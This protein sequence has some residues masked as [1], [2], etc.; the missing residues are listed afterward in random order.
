MTVFFPGVYGMGNF[1]MKNC[2]LSFFRWWA[3]RWDTSTQAML[4]VARHGTLGNWCP[5]CQWEFQDPKMKVLY[6]IRSHFVG[7]S[8]YIYGR[9]LQFRFLKWPLILGM[10]NPEFPSWGNASKIA[11]LVGPELPA[12]KSNKSM[13]YFMI[14]S[15]LAI[16][17]L[18][19]S[20]DRIGTQWHSQWW[21]PESTYL[22]YFP[23]GLYQAQLASSLQK[24]RVWRVGMRRTESGHRFILGTRQ[25]EFAC[26]FPVAGCWSCFNSVEVRTCLLRFVPD[27]QRRTKPETFRYIQIHSDTFSWHFWCIL[28]IWMSWWHMWHIDSSIALAVRSHIPRLGLQMACSNRSQAG[29]LLLLYGGVY[30]L[31][32]VGVCWLFFHLISY[33]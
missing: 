19:F 10:V 21:Y 11:W 31:V 6:H 17:P 4:R 14:I 24:P 27:S 25:A 3:S 28:H 18:Q 1:L 9:Y 23:E 26:A 30:E 22:R 29:H 5:S 16:V 15:W 2:S 12:K 13:S 7:I 20:F 32:Y 8:P 33:P